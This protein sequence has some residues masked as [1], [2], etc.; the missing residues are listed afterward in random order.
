MNLVDHM[1]DSVARIVLHAFPATSEPITALDAI[2]WLRGDIERPP[3]QEDADAVFGLLEHLPVHQME[4]IVLRLHE[5]ELLASADGDPEAPN[6]YR[7]AEGQSV[8]QGKR[9]SGFS[10]EAILER[11]HNARMDMRTRM[12]Y[13]SLQQVRA[14]MAY[15]EGLKPHRLCS[16][17]VLMELAQASPQD[18]L[19]LESIRELHGGAVSRYGSAFLEVLQKVHRHEAH[20]E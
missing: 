13:K 3:H 15:T 1:G 12:R 20:R 5:L 7:T 8:C 16:N 14:Q 10:M 9:P 19:S 6:W 2:H 17:Y 11:R 4:H 18:L